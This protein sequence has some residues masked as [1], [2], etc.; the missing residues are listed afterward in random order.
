M[1]VTDDFDFIDVGM[2][3]SLEF[4]FELLDIGHVHAPSLVIE[5]TQWDA[6]LSP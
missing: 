2:P 6:D 4:N 3:A 1:R 5:R